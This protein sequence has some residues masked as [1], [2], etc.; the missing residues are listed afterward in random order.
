[1][2]QS[3]SPARFVAAYGEDVPVRLRAVVETISYGANGVAVGLE[4]GEELL[5]RRALV[6]VST[7]VLAAGKIAFEPPL[8]DWKL[9]AIAGLPM[10]L[11]NKVVM[12]FRADLF[13]GTPSNSCGSRISSA[14][15]IR[16]RPRVPDA[17]WA[18]N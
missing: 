6:T 14:T 11:M 1:M 18:T 12:E 7:G 16:S 8:P 4:N 13:A 9:A 17:N 5:G 10:G 2:W 3:S 15:S